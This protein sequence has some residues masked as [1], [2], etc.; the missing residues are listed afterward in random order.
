V[1]PAAGNGISFFPG[2]SNGK[3]LSWSFIPGPPRTRR[4]VIV[5]EVSYHERLFYLFEAEK[6]PPVEESD[7]SITTLVVHAP[8][9]TPLDDGMLSL[10]LLHGARHRGV[11]LSEWEWPEL[12]RRKFV[13]QSVAVKRFAE[14]FVEY[15]QEFVPP[16]EEA[17][18]VSLPGTPGAPAASPHAT[19]A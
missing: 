17:S 4:R 5:A 3:T 1:S 14:R 12:L 6:R 15:F 16:V 8:D 10:I 11:W 7:E 9:G 18:S 19:T 13:H 2:K